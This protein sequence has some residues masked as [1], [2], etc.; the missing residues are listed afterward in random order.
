MKHRT[1]RL[2]AW[3]LLMALP[4]LFGVIVV[5]FVL[6]RALPGDPAI[7]YASG[8]NMSQEDID[9]IRR[10]MGLDKSVFEQ[11]LLYLNNIA[12]LNFGNSLVTGQPVLK[13]FGERLPATLELA[14][15]AFALSLVV[16]LPVGVLSALYRDSWIDQLV[17]VITSVSA[18]MP[19]FF[20]GLI[21]IFIFYFLMG[22]APEP[23]G[24]LSGW[25]IAPPTVT[26]FMTIDAA[27]IGDWEIFW[28]A[29][30]KMLMP[31]ASMAIFAVAPLMRMMRG[32][33][34]DALDSDY[35]KAARA[36]G[37]PRRK[38]LL[39]Y[40]LPNAMLP[41]LATMGM[42]LSTML[43]ANIMIEKLFAWPGIGSYSVN[44]LTGVDYAPVQAFVLIVAVLFV[45]MTLAIDILSAAIDPRYKLKG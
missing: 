23:I 37:I 15:F 24:R 25:S 26:G 3:R 10:A 7:V 21:L 45:L 44:A 16:A 39:Q 27:L 20:F 4:I 11:F 12:H 38:I 34:I 13:D 35:I 32:G 1:L 22:I 30:G 36:Y 19:G 17:R 28:E 18:A 41:V 31:A 8:P 9:A 5:T 14:V 42:V 33:M 29:L 43:G 2:I 40:A 6:I